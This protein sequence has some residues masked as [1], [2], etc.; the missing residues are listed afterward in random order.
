MPITITKES[1]LAEVV[2]L[3]HNFW[4]DYNWNDKIE[5]IDLFKFT[6][7]IMISST[8]KTNFYINYNIGFMRGTENR[9]WMPLE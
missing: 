5:K 1:S 7:K 2:V 6:G 9:E 3:L 8:T 4:T